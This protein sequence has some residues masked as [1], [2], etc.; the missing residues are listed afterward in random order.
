MSQRAAFLHGFLRDPVTVV[1]SS[2]RSLNGRED[3]A[4]IRHQR[5]RKP[6]P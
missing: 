3:R 6:C 5:T 4:R 2:S 1:E